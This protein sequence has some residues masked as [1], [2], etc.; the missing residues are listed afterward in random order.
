MG[1]CLSSKK[2][3]S[4]LEKKEEKKTEIEE[5]DDEEDDDETEDEECFYAENEEEAAEI[6]ERMAKY[7]LAKD[8]KIHAKELMRKRKHEAAGDIKA[9]DMLEEQLR[10]R[11]R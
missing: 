7:K 9:T 2:I 8:K 1:G 3:H 10:D 4:D 5:V 11:W 6:R